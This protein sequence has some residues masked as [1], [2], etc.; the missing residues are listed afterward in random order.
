MGTRAGMA[1]QEQLEPAEIDG[2][3]ARFHR[4]GDRSARNRVVE[5][6]LH[7]VG[8]QVRRFSRGS[9]ASAD[10]V[11]QAALMALIHAADRYE[12]GR[13]ASFRTFASRTIEGELKRYLRDRS[14]AVRPPRARQEL[15]LAISRT[16][17]EL[18]HE[19]GRSPT[20]DEVAQRAGVDRD[21]VLEGMEAGHARIADSLDTTQRSDDG[22][23]FSNPFGGVDPSFEAAES[24]LDLRAALSELGERERAVLQMRF[25][26]ERTQPEIA[27]ALQISQSYV[28]RILREALTQLRATMEAGDPHTD[29]V[30]RRSLD[31]DDTRQPVTSSTS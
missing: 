25:L 28:S 10:D 1:S 20:L 26:D 7:M 30:G 3:L 12:P 6:H 17:E 27:E 29:E 16:S 4:D 23:E 31:P 19:L 14:W 2:L 11:R 21:R 5:A 8:F 15:H 24:H 13:G 18:S 22:G 9:S